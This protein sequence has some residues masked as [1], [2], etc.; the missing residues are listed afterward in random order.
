MNETMNN[1]NT[2]PRTAYN[3]YLRRGI[4]TPEV[5]N[6]APSGVGYLLPQLWKPSWST[7]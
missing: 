4:Q 2:D 5:L 6:E 1:I 3:Q 7:P